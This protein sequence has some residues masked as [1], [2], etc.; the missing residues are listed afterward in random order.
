MIWSIGSGY[1]GNALLGKKCFALRIAN[2]DPEILGWTEACARRLGFVV[3]RDQTNRENGLTSLRIAGGPSEHLRFFHLT[4]PAITRKRDIEGQLVKTFANLRVA[5][6]E[7]LG[8]ELPLYDITTGT[9]DF[10]A[11]GV[12]SHNC[13]A[14]PTHEY[15]GFS[16]GLDF[17]SKIVVKENAPELL[18]RELS[19]KKWKP[20]TLVMSG[21]TD[22]YQPV[23]RRR[24]VAGGFRRR[25]RTLRRALS[26]KKITTRYVNLVRDRAASICLCGGP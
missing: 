12:V 17:E 5:A 23:E 25:L 4:D 1:G 6:I 21:V 3:A 20:Q 26:V 13:F 7:P 14:R 22:C 11:N 18:R 8:R 15:L 16:A 10:I 2:T 9:G 24:G 19:S